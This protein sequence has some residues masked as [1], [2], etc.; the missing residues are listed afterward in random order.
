M[1]QRTYKSILLLPSENAPEAVLRPHTRRP[2]QAVAR[3]KQTFQQQLE[4]NVPFISE[5]DVHQIASFMTLVVKSPIGTG[6]TRLAAH[7]MRHQAQTLKRPPRVLVLTHRQAL[8]R[9]LTKRL[10]QELDDVMIFENYQGLTGS[11]LRQ[12]DRLVI[13]VNSVRKLAAIGKPLPQYDLIFIDE[14]EQLLAHLDGGTFKGDAALQADRCLRMLINQAGQVIV[15]DADAGFISQEWLKELRGTPYVLLNTYVRN[16]GTL[17][18]YESLEKLVEVGNALIKKN[19]GP[20]VYA[21]NSIKEAQRLQRYYRTL[22]E[23]DVIYMLCSQNSGT[24]Q[25]QD[26]IQNINRDLPKLK[27]FIYTPSL[28][29][30]VDIQYPIRALFGIFYP[31]PLAS[32]E[33]HQMLG[34]CRNVK[35]THVHLQQRGQ[36]RAT[37]RDVLFR[38]FLKNAAATGKQ[39][40]FDAHGVLYV[41]PAQETLLK[42]LCE[43]RA[44]RNRSKN[45]LFT[46]FREEALGYRMEWVEGFS[47]EVQGALLSAKEA[48]AEEMKQSIL[49]ADPINNEDYEQTYVKTENIEAGHQR[50]LLEQL[51]GLP[52]TAQIYDDFYKEA[53]REELRYFTDL[54]DDDGL[55]KHR[56]R[57]EALKNVLITKWRH[58]SLRRQHVESVLV[59]LF[60]YEWYTSPE[61]ITKNELEQRLG[62]YLGFHQEDMIN[63]LGVQFQKKA[64]LTTVLRQILGCVGLEVEGRQQMRNRTRSYVYSLERTRLAKM[65][66]YAESRLIRLKRDRQE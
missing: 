20:I 55:L 53:D 37:D 17:F 39:C 61:T 41:T 47:N 44:Q 34:R 22:Y 45:H 62:P 57:E 51:V 16:R 56:A 35:D 11:A 50:Y 18:L 15:M 6:K 46:H 25:A 33:L 23:L 54:L 31:E 9:D 52:I 14:V 36:Y 3:G 29:T 24:E 10:N 5:I 58:R 21:T 13:C 65:R 8:A 42:L 60:G 38:R 19:E 49:N 59:L 32:S 30:G 48:T 43:I 2:P 63:L 27:V 4:V 1:T 66:R 28:G 26:F 12:I 64:R 40:D 7:L